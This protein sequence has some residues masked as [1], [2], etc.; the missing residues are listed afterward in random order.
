MIF[1]D[2]LRFPFWCSIPIARRLL[3]PF[4]RTTSA[5]IRRETHGSRGEDDLHVGVVAGETKNILE[6]SKSLVIGVIF[7]A[8]VCSV[9][10]QDLSRLHWRVTAVGS[11][12]LPENPTSGI[13]ETNDV[14]PI[15]KSRL[16]MCCN[17]L[18]MAN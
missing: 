14:S 8:A 4:C 1:D 3:S 12:R 17:N 11:T 7:L 5:T 15:L 18:Q 10:S 13:S 16:G 9:S 2:F 6:T